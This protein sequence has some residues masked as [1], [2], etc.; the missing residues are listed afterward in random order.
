[1]DA[2]W[3]IPITIYWDCSCNSPNFYPLPGTLYIYSGFNH[4]SHCPLWMPLVS[5]CCLHLPIYLSLC[6]CFRLYN[7]KPLV[8]CNIEM[9]DWENELLQVNTNLTP[10]QP[11][12]NSLVGLDP[13]RDNYRDHRSHRHRPLLGEHACINKSPLQTTNK[14]MVNQNTELV[15]QKLLLLNW[16]QVKIWQTRPTLAFHPCLWYPE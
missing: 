10:R 14:E 13:L 2:I 6:H 5:L 15:V 7:Y 4:V 9:I 16:D 12:P 3:G 11:G 1:M 8:L